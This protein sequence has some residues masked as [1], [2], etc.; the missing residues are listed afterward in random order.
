MLDNLI[1]FSV[2]NKFIIAML[3]LSVAVWGFYAALRLP[4][5]AVPDIT[6]NQVQVVLVSPALTPLEIE[7][8]V[9]MPIEL[10]VANLPQVEQVRSVS[11]F[12][13]SIVTIVFE[14]HADIYRAR[15]LVAEQLKIAEQNIPANFGKPELMPIT[16]GLG[17]VY[18]YTLKPQKGYEDKFSAT[19]LRSIQDWQIKRQLSGIQGVIEISSFGG[20]LKQYE[21]AV[22]P[23]ELRSFGLTINDVFAAVAADNQNAGGSYIEKNH[24]R[25]YIRTEGLYKSI[26]EIENTVVVNRGG[27]PILVKDIA[28]VR[29]GAAPR[30]GAMTQDG[31]GEAVGGI[32]LMLKGAN[33]YQVVENIKARVEI[34]QK[35]LPEGLK[36]EPYLERTGLID[37][38][39]ETVSKNL[40]EGGLIVIFVLVVLLGNLRAGF[41]VASVIPLSMLSALGMMY[42][43]GVS[44]NLMS[45]GAIDFGLIVDGSVII[46][47]NMVHHLHKHYVG[48][49]LSRGE[50]DN[51][52]YT[53]SV[54]IRSSASFGEIIILMVYLPILSLTGIE[55]KMFAPMAQTVIFAIL[56]AFIFSLTYV[57]MMSAL[58]LS[59]KVSDKESFSDKMI[60]YLQKIYKPILEKALRF[61]VIVLTFT[62][63]AFF[64][65]L[66]LFMNMGGEFIPTLEEGDLAMQM[67]LPPGSSLQES[68]NASLEAEKIL[69]KY[70]PEV[71]GV[72][73]KIG[74]AEIPTDPMSI[75]DTDVMILLKPK[76]EWTSAKDREELAQKM[77]EKLAVLSFANFEFSQPI[78]LRFN[79]LITG[80]KSDLAVKI[81]GEDLQMLHEKAKEA[82]NLIKDVQGVGDI[83][84]EQ[85]EGMPQ[86]VVRPDRAK[87]AQHGLTLA[88]INQTLEA[89]FAGVTASQIFE[90]EKR[91]DMVVRF[92]DL[93]RNS[94]QDVANLYIHLPNGF[95]IPLKELASVEIEENPAMISRENTRRRITVGINVRNRD[96][97]S[98]VAEISGILDQKLK[99]PPGYEVRYGGQFENLQAA[100]SRLM[101]AVPVA[102]FL[103]FA[104]LFFTFHSLGQAMLIFSAVPLSAIGGVLALWLRDMPFSISAGVGFIALFGVAVLNGIVLI[105]HYNE[106]KKEGEALLERTIHGAAD[107]LRPVLMTAATAALGFLPMAVSTAAGAEVQKPLAT[108][109]IGGLITATFLTLFVLPIL[110]GL[111]EKKD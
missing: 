5:D 27:K 30:L 53:A 11:K 6:N 72:V 70:F 55:G 41:V 82:E 15:Q 103:I 105:G 52:V 77:K 46:V 84:T 40:I 60:A 80:A 22:S 23:D 74:T 3:T 61:R 96:I 26:P 9:T 21:I 95:Q 98:L 91:F 57:P 19:D 110:Y 94:L 1:G 83:R 73:A 69:M 32:V 106:L 81:Y 68:V 85:T 56:G 111:L 71:R 102:L 62:F 4:L 29:I 88:E 51:A 36:I 2:R 10:A 67:V 54:Q 20:F 64:G 17:E 93:N 65:S 101:I 87:L 63:S 48:K 79:E 43:F 78:E 39:I 99:L 8:S 24:R 47:E 50:M 49:K 59:K 7:R 38:A 66:W 108:V 28:E 34:V 37:R 42:V 100:K 33:S 12:G 44:A 58:I 92:K 35:S 13:L 76:S 90:G 45:L 25:Y 14:E 89:A 104:L 18:Q 75:E 86:I 107:R 16:T 97:E 109:V 31:Q